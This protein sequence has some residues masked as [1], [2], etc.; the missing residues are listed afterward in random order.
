MT[1]RLTRLHGAGWRA[2]E[3][4]SDTREAGPGMLR[5]L[6]DWT[7]DLSRH[8]HALWALAIVSFV[9]SSV[10]PIPPDIMLIPMVL[11]ARDRAWLIAAV[12][13]AASVAG[14]L[15]GYLIGAFLFDQ[16][17][18]PVLEFYSYAPRFE[19]FRAAYNEWGAWAV[20]T[21][22]ITPFPYKVITILSGVT[23]LDP[24]VF[25]LSSILARGVR[26]F[27]VAA[28]LWKFGAP[29]RGFIEAR[30]GLLFTI[31]IIL[32]FGGFLAAKLFL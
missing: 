32:L 24:L 21:A 5:R 3:N 2:L 14:G 18:Q 30:L 6:Y 16:V 29:I 8:P 22:G 11:A 12:C 9:E 10:F 27:L 25:T 20:F 15:L 26:F 1:N 17:G 31:F 28:L 19:E 23:G 7:L 4:K 13:T